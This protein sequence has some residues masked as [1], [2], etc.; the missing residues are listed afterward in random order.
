MAR[1]SSSVDRPGVVVTI[2]LCPHCDGKFPT[3][4]RQTVTCIYRKCLKPF[5]VEDNEFEKKKHRLLSDTSYCS[6]HVRF[7]ESAN[8]KGECGCLKCKALAEREDDDRNL[9][10]WQRY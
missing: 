9:P 2:V 10:W 6:C 5:N 7:C 4:E 8:C 1:D 3:E